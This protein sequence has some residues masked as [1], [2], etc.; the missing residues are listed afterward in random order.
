MLFFE[1]GIVNT[2]NTFNFVYEHGIFM[3]RLTEYEL[4]QGPFRYKLKVGF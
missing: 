3:S 1:K 4:T 2:K